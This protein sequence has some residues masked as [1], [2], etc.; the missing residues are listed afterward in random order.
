MTYNVQ[1]RGSKFQIRIH[2]TKL[3]PKARFFT[4]DEEQAARDYG[5]QC[6]AWFATGQVPAELLTIDKL[7]R[8][9]LLTEACRSYTNATEPAPTITDLDSLPLLM[10][11]I[12]GV[13][14]A[15]V[16]FAWAQN[17]VKALKA[18]NPAP[19]P[20]TIRKRV[21]LL[22]RVL[23]HHFRSIY[24]DGEQVPANVMRM[25]PKGYSLYADNSVADTSRDL[26]LDAA[27][28]A[29]IID[30]L[31]GKK[32][33]DKERPWGNQGADGE[34]D[35]A[36]KLLYELIVDT[37]VRLREAYWMRAGYLDV[38][39]RFMKVAGT[40]GHRGVIKW[41]TVPLKKEI[42]EKLRAA[43][44]ALKP[45]DLVFP[46]WNG[47]RDDLD[48]CSARLSARFTTMFRYSSVP[49]LT[50]HDLR[51]EAC[52]RWVTLK[53]REGRWMF[54]DGEICRIMGWSDP[55]L[56]LRYMSLRGEDLAARLH[57]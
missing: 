9:P 10:E 32:A 51:H 4:Y 29:R 7:A 47:T 21:G 22:G 27:Q 39:G 49:E 24:K 56:L 1:P 25:L 48:K 13:R 18:R 6:E 31:D 33:E 45:D 26:R 52:C 12:K 55:K 38:Q 44:E 17:F 8:T 19:T 16:N 40:K 35:R 42:Y 34:P 37:G 43:C 20:G 23:D 41:R 57:F 53:D 11:E 2:H 30:T 15:D 50:E 5:E 46:F 14:I 54:T 3:M 36:F 28:H